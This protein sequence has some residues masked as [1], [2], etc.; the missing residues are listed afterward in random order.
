MLPEMSSR[1]AATRGF[2]VK[3]DE[4]DSIDGR[5]SIDVVL[6]EEGDARVLEVSGQLKEAVLN[7]QRLTQQIQVMQKS[8][9]WRILAPIRAV[10]RL[11]KKLKSGED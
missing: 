9:S 10:G 1:S 6:S 5:R 8:T 11:K 7:V 3:D 4:M 2:R